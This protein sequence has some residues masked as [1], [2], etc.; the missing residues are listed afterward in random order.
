[1]KLTVKEIKN[2][3]AYIEAVLTEAEVASEKEHA[4]DELI[5][6]VT[7][8][9][10]RQGKAPKSIAA[11][12]VDPDKLSN[13]ILS[14]VL[15]NIVSS[16]LKENKYRLLGRPVLENIDSKENKGWVIKLSL[17]LFPEINVENYQKLFTK[18]KTKEA[19]PK[20]E[21]ERVEK[22]YQT[23]LDN[24]KVEVPE[25]V[26]EEEVNYSL[27]RLETQAKTLNLTLENYLKAVKKTIDQV[28]SEYS[29]RAEESIKLDLILLEIAKVEKIDTTNQEIKEVAKAGGVPENQLAQLKTIINR[30][31]TIE[32]LLKL[33]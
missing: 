25:S 32:I 19:K 30:R 27:E 6:T 26:V 13:H 15:N 5:S 24:I 20:T 10:F 31:K 4:V 2:N 14:H 3:T 23:L 7:V 18:I 8:K 11:E 29:K 21:E 28:K 12:H 16:A 17:P 33:C 1:M 9:G 22:I